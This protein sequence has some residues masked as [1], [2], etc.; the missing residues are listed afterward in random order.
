MK[1]T[2]QSKEDSPSSAAGFGVKRLVRCCQ[3]LGIKNGVRY[4]RLQRQAAKRPEIVEVWC[5]MWL[6]GAGEEDAKGNHLSAEILRAFV[7]ETREL[8]A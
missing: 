5:E 6:R 1:T 8:N 3:C 7:K 4:W 2:N